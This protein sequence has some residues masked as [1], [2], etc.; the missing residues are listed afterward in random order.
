MKYLCLG[1]YDPD[2][3]DGLS[4]AERL[5]MVEACAPHD[6]EL[7]ASG[8]VQSVASLEHGVHVTLRPSGS[9]SGT[10][11]TD[12]P[13]AEA[14]ELVGSFFIIDAADLDEAVRI[15]SLHPAARVRPDL[16]FAVEVRP[17]EVLGEVDPESGEMELVQGSPPERY[18]GS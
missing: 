13:F 16:G 17:I 12:G 3:F 9:G 1:Y 7:R 18:G 8:R 15:A 14:K 5:A 10:S 6:A 11:V 4:E 2:A